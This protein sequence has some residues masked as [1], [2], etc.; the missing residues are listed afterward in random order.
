VE[1]GKGIRLAELL[2]EKGIDT[3]YLKEDFEGKG[4]EYVFS[5]AE[6]DVRKT[7]LQNLKELI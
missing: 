6:V 4:P 3:L 5:D 1:K 7:N 2:V